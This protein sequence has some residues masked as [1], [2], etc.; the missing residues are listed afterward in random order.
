[1]IITNAPNNWDQLK[2]LLNNSSSE[3]RLDRFHGRLDSNE[4]LD[5]YYILGSLRIVLAM[6]NHAKLWLVRQNHL[7]ILVLL[8]YAAGIYDVEYT[9]TWYYI[10][11]SHSIAG[12]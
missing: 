10:P 1:M 4:E 12:Y 7:A 3:Y 9:P 8:S 5:L 2:S 6:I 11:F